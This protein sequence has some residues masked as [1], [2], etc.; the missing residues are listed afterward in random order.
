PSTA[1]RITCRSSPASSPAT[2]SAAAPRRFDGTLGAIPHRSGQNDVARLDPIFERLFKEQGKELIFDAGAAAI[3]RGPAGEIPVLRQQLTAQ[4][5]AGVF[6]ELVPDDLR[7]NFPAPGVTRFDYAFAGGRVS[8]AF[9][10]IEGR[11]RAV[12]RPAGDLDEDVSSKLELASAAELLQDYM[13]G[14]A[15][16]PGAGSAPIPAQTGRRAVVKDI[17]FRG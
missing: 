11:V 2:P 13:H 10:R 15:S 14:G 1:C 4:Q 6:A 8:I 3:L 5:I 9:E 17:S 16:V 12:V 7:P